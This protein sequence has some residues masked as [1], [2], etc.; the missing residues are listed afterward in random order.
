MRTD[1][2]PFFFFWYVV[3]QKVK[4]GFRSFAFPFCLFK[5]LESK[6]FLVLVALQVLAKLSLIAVEFLKLS[7]SIS[8]CFSSLWAWDCLEPIVDFHFI[9]HLGFPEK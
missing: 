4:R 7:Y 9:C 1:Y 3:I 2:F 5:D 8:I 6:I